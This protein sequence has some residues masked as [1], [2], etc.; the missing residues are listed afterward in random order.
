MWQH[1]SPI[2]DPQAACDLIWLAVKFV[3]YVSI[4]ACIHLFIHSAACLTT[5]PY[6]L[7]K[8]VL[9]RVRSNASYFNFHYPRVSWKSSNSWLRLLPRLL[10]TSLL[11]SI[12]P[13]ITCFRRQFLLKMWPIQLAFLLLTVRRIF[14]SSLTLCNTS[15]F[16]TKSVQ[17]IASILLHHYIS[18]HKYCAINGAVRCTIFYHLPRCGPG[19]RP[20]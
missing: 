17:L 12:F 8:L 16:L 14:L 13:P 1:G 20:Q 4:H 5:G 7:L 2:R 15:L 9:H 3:N 6:P 10:F 11:P 18:Y 19:T